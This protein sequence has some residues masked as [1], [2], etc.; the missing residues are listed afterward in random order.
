MS[1]HGLHALTRLSNSHFWLASLSY[2]HIT[3]NCLGDTQASLAEVCQLGSR[4]DIQS[5]AEE[6][7]DA[8]QEGNVAKLTALQKQNLAEEARDVVGREVSKLLCVVLP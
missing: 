5:E 4:S 6:R 3:V 1:A 7:L 8:E 2:F